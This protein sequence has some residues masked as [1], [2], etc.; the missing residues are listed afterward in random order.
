M[1]IGKSIRSTNSPFLDINSLLYSVRSFVWLSTN[2]SVRSLV[3]TSVR[4]SVSSSIIS[5]WL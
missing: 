5:I 4:D 1:D 3:N 2:N